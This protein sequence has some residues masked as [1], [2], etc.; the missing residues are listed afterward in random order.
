M[1]RVFTVNSA[2]VVDA[3]HE[4]FSDNWS[5]FV[6]REHG[7]IAPDTPLRRRFLPRLAVTLAVLDLLF[8]FAAMAIFIFAIRDRLGFS[9]LPGTASAVACIG[10][11]SMVLAYATGCYRHD[12]F[13]DFSTAT[14]RL[15]VGLGV[16]LVFLLPL[17]HFGL[18]L[19][20]HSLA[21]RSIS[22]N[23]TIV[24]IGV[25]AGLCGGMVSR[26]MFMAM[27]RRQWF[28]RTILIIGTGRRARHLCDVLARVD[29]R[30]T[31]VHFLTEACLGG[32]PSRDV[33]GE[34]VDALSDA[35]GATELAAK[36]DVD[37][38][39]L[40][41]DDPREL[42]FDHLLP[43]KANGIPIVDFNTF[44][45]SETGRV[46]ITWT[47]PDWLLY[48]DGFR[49]GHL[50]RALKRLMD[51][52]ISICVLLFTLPASLLVAGVIVLTDF[53]PVFYRQ[54]R[55][56]HKGRPFW[57]LKFRTMRV[58]AE[59]NGAQWAREND[60]RIT[61]VGRFLRRI[62]IDE[63]PQMINVLRGE[64]SLVGPRP[65]RP[66]FVDDLAK[67][68]RLYHLR[69]SAKAGV[70]GWAQINYPY[71]A[72]VEDAVRKLEYDL[73][74]LKN[75]SVLRDISIILQT[76]RILLFAKGGR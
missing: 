7:A 59:E 53:G 62:R 8:M 29:R 30:P 42:Y 31:Q 3:N 76:L 22:R 69:H 67:R 16:G 63:I 21:F 20:F 43:W 55:V 56:S 15:A 61:R 19:A 18:G 11:V 32:T 38:V 9:T 24:L 68:I 57:I 33:S 2:A 74:Y 52:G 48:S 58:D 49:F 64:M 47:E 1:A 37:Q 75:F 50:D 36:L 44:L 46:D 70:T 72:S 54:Q 40:A 35:L 26:I 45:E 51:L 66:F 71:G 4:V 28:R 60:P 34:D 41:V 6:I 65:E 5:R 25:G 27:I 12:A 39:V 13:V 14:T 73:Y 23:L 17:M 10:L